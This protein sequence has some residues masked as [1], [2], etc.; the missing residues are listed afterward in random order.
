MEKYYS[1]RAVLGTCFKSAAAL[2]M[3]STIGP[4]LLS[5]CKK[6]CSLSNQNSKETHVDA[7][8]VTLCPD[9]EKLNEQEKSLRSSLKYVDKSPSTERTCD[10][11]KLYTLPTDKS[12]CGGCKIVPGPIHPKGYCVAWVYRM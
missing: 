1:R 11:C 3:V 5:A 2:F 4:G 8:N 9:Q 12:P 7:S 6:A 10:N